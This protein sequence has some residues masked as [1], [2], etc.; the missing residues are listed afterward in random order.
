MNF[1][2]FTK[3]DYEYIVN[4]CMLDTEYQKLLEYKIK[5]YS[6]TKMA[7]ELGVSESTIDIM[8]KRLKKK[9]RKII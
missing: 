7:M 4:E 5:G 3:A 2:D 1:F 8:T 9:I 6:R